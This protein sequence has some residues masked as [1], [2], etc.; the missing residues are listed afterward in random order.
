MSLSRTKSTDAA[1][2][3]SHSSLQANCTFRLNSNDLIQ[4]L[5]FHYWFILPDVRI[6]C[7]TFRHLKYSNF[8][9]ARQGQFV[10]GYTTGS[11]LMQPDWL[12]KSLNKLRKQEELNLSPPYWRIKAHN[13]PVKLNIQRENHSVP[14]LYYGGYTMLFSLPH[15]ISS[16][17]EWQLLCP[18]HLWLLLMQLPSSHMNSS[19]LHVTV[20][21]NY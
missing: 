6:I 5:N 10:M 9:S 11:Q 18:S 3:S 17:P 21:N 2:R 12:V 14:W 7:T 20:T 15:A 16:E 1:W 4:S 8:Y 13:V 19:S